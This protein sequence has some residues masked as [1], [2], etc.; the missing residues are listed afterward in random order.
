MLE[1]SVRYALPSNDALAVLLFRRVLLIPRSPFRIESEST[2]SHRAISVLL[3]MR[4]LP[5]ALNLVNEV[6]LLP[7]AGHFLLLKERA[8][9]RYCQ[10]SQFARVQ[11]LQ[12]FVFEVLC[13]AAGS[14]P[15]A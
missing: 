10:S 4:R 8:Q 11:V 15:D 5:P 14:R 3:V 12:H 13:R 6:F 1:G 2:T 7:R 9:L